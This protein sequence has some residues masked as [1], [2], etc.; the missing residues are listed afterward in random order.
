MAS[1]M[2][3]DDRKKLL[4]RQNTL[5]LLTRG[6]LG[7]FT[8][9]LRTHRGQCTVRRSWTEVAVGYESELVPRFAPWTKRTLAAFTAQQLPSG[10]VLVPACGP[11]Q[12][13]LLLAQSLEGREIIGVDLA[14]GMV[15]VKR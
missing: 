14:E 5:P 10:P 12:E 11:G 3:A 15:Q 2:A 1:S 7:L 13:L 9:S 8:S 6:F 4:A